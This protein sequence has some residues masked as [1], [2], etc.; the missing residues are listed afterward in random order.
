MLAIRR[1]ATHHTMGAELIDF[2]EDGDSLLGH[3]R[4]FLAGRFL[5]WLNEHLFELVRSPAKGVEIDAISL[6]R[7]NDFV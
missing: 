5:R 2:A 4:R 1:I 3:F 7:A 6:E